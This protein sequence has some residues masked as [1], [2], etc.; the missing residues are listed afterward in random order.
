VLRL[1]SKRLLAGGNRRLT[2]IF[3]EKHQ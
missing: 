1:G 3:F 2:Q